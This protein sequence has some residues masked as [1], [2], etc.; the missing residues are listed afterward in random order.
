[1]FVYKRD[2]YEGKGK[3][4]ANERERNRERRVGRVGRARDRMINTYEL[5]DSV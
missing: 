1:M 4:E 3:E 5:I 2:I